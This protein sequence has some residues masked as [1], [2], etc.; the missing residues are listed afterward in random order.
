MSYCN[1]KTEQLNQDRPRKEVVLYLTLEKGPL[2][3]GY[4]IEGGATRNV[5]WE[6]QNGRNEQ[7]RP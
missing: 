2:C 5:R 7:F 6:A 4:S 3:G 1:C